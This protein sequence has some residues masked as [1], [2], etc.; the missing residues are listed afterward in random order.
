MVDTLKQYNANR[1]H[2]GVD[3]KMSCL[4]LQRGI[5]TIVLYVKDKLRWTSFHHRGQ[6]ISKKVQGNAFTTRGLPVLQAIVNQ[7]SELNMNAL[8][9]AFEYPWEHLHPHG[10]TS[11]AILRQVHKD[12]A[13]GI[14]AARIKVFPFPRACNDF[15]HLMGKTKE[16]ESRCTVTEM[17]GNGEF[18]KTHFDYARSVLYAIQNC[19]VVDLMNEVWGGYLRRLVCL[20]EIPSETNKTKLM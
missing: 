7:E 3:V 20:S 18:K 4:Q 13:A 5:A 2:I 11:A 8:F 15:F 14:E 6:G 16:M 12:F 10:P 17:K 1:M 9:R 19:P